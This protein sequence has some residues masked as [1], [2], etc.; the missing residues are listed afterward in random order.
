M[1]ATNPSSGDLASV[2][3]PLLGVLNLASAEQT[4]AVLNEDGWTII[5]ISSTADL[6][7]YTPHLIHCV[8]LDSSRKP[9]CDEVLTFCEQ[10][11]SWRSVPKV[12]IA[13]PIAEYSNLVRV[14]PHAVSEHLVSYVRT[15][16]A[17]DGVLSTT[18][19]PPVDYS[20]R[21]RHYRHRCSQHVVVRQFGVLVDISAGGAALEV[22]Y[23]LP[24]GTT[25]TVPVC[26]T[27][28]LL[29]LLE[30]E[31]LS[32]NRRRNNAWLVHVRFLKITTAVER[33]MQR[34]ILSLQKSRLY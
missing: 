4:T 21:R 12:M 33:A 31:V 28:P 25:I 15:S 20:D 27:D 30:A 10:S 6:A 24:V 13:P 11:Y 8:L 2:R 17:D 23:S 18:T 26:E 14:P 34:H 9:L 19:A 32:S 3:L 5:R 22:P 29:R 7:K 16:Q 1:S